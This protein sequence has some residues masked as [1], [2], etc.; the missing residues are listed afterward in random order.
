MRGKHK[1]NVLAVLD[2][3]N[4]KSTT[5]VG[6]KLGIAVGCAAY[7]LNM[8][9][10]EGKVV[11]DRQTVHHVDSRAHSVRYIYRLRTQEDAPVEAP[12]PVV[13]PAYRNMRLNET[14]TG[15]GSSLAQFAGLCMLVRR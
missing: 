10:E 14:L 3:H 5:E 8:L 1:E 9:A 6:Q 4:W 15:Y 7:Y 12:V 2:E 13:Q 11:Q